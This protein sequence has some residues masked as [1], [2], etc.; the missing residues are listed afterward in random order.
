[1]EL[2]VYVF[3][4]SCSGSNT[5]FCTFLLL[6]ISYPS[7]ARLSGINL[8][9]MKLARGVNKLASHQILSFFFFFFLIAMMFYKWHWNSIFWPTKATKAAYYPSCFFPNTSSWPC[10]SSA[11]VVLPLKKEVH[12]SKC[13][14]CKPPSQCPSPACL[15]SQYSNWHARRTLRSG[16]TN[17]LVHLEVLR[18]TLSITMGD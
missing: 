7:A 15:S 4:S 1:M 12:L 5:T 13:H 11:K 16:R 9:V 10:F 8:S 3:L 18:L 17:L 6:K 2:H 14:F